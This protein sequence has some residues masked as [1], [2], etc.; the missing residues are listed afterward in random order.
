MRVCTKL[1]LFLFMSYV[2]ISPAIINATIPWSSSIACTDTTNTKFVPSWGVV[3]VDKDQY[4]KYII[5]WMYWDN[6]DRLQWFKDTSDSTFEP[7]ALFDGSSSSTQ[8]YGY[9]PRSLPYGHGD[10]GYWSSDLP[11]P[12]QD[13][14][15]GDTGNEWVAT[16]GSAEANLISSKK[17][18]YTVTRV[19]DG[20]AKNGGVKLSAQRGRRADP[21]T[22]FWVNSYG[23]WNSYGCSS[24]AY[25]FT[26]PWNNFVAPGCRVY[27]YEWTISMNR[28]C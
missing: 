8:L 12:Y 15:W 5:Q 26:L 27:W 17:V 14:A 4:G 25:V 10:Y 24:N 23:K 13:T 11:S 6:D 19:L 20:G 16:V 9:F 28:A 7:D 21:T 1:V 3:L 2:A 22:P 18:Y